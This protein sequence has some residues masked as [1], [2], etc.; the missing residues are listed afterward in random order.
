MSHGELRGVM[1]PDATDSVSAG[2]GVGVAELS[3]Q[4]VS[5]G[6]MML[7]SSSSGPSSITPFCEVTEAGSS[8]G[9]RVS[10]GSHS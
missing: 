9:G 4:K 3:P 8:A 10:G 7:D 6:A 5:G 2:W 1:V